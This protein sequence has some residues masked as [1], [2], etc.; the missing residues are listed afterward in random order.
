[1]VNIKKKK[2][3]NSFLYLRSFDP[4]VE[5]TCAAV[6]NKCCTPATADHPNAREA[7]TS[8]AWHWRGPRRRYLGTAC[9][10]RAEKDLP[11]PEP[12]PLRGRMH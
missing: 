3:R 1:M 2:K 10:T 11:L 6:G 4:A 9:T 8:G 5:C 7:A 12:H